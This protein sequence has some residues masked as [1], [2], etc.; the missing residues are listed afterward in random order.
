MKALCLLSLEGPLL[1]PECCQ[2][3]HSKVYRDQR[4]SSQCRYL[5][6]RTDLSSEVRRELLDIVQALSYVLLY[7]TCLVA[8]G[9]SGG[10]LGSEYLLEDGRP[11]ADADAGAERAEEI[12]A[13]NNDGC[14]FD[15]GISQETNKCRRDAW[16]IDQ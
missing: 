4:Q 3:R 14:V 16:K 15:S 2:K 7:L 9:E 13:R 6:A 5:V 12:R 1:D 8:V 11:G 10:Q